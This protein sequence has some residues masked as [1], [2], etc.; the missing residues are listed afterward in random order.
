[1]AK[2][3]K[4]AACNFA[5][6]PVSSFDEFAD[7]VRGL[8]DQTSGADLVLFHFPIPFLLLL[9]RRVKS[10]PVA[11]RN[12]AIML[13]LVIACDVMWETAIRRMGA[14]PSMLHGSSGVH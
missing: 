1:M 4:I 13:L 11:L 14:E 6:R 5:V 8:L 12:I 3:V 9:F 2:T 10:N 7:H